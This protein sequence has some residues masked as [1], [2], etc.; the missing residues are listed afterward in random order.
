[1]SQTSDDWIPVCP[2][3]EDLSGLGNVDVSGECGQSPSQPIL[4][5]GHSRKV[6][7]DCGRWRLAQHQPHLGVADLEPS[8]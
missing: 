6:H 1:M 7:W 8:D 5:P 4:M 3:P 2:A